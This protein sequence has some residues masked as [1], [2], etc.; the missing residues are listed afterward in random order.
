[1]FMAIVLSIPLGLLASR[2]P[3]GSLD[4]LLT[5]LS[6]VGLSVPQFFLGSIMVIG[7]TVKLHWFETG[8]GSPGTST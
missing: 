6:L 8:A 7:F 5:T 2:R 1:M 3:G 4:R